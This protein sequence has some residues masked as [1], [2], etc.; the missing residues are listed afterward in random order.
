MLNIQQ[1]P[2]PHS[3]EQALQVSWLLKFKELKNVE[4]YI[5]S[6]KKERREEEKKKQTKKSTKNQIPLQE[7]NILLTWRSYESNGGSQWKPT[8][9]KGHNHFWH[10]YV[11]PTWAY[12]VSVGEVVHHAENSY[13]RHILSL[14]VPPGWHVN[15]DT[16]PAWNRGGGGEKCQHDAAFHH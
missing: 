4:G 10:H 16:L 9:D 1:E 2:G 13:S 7:T 12:L 5:F 14:Q 8:E 11:V 3:S 15:K 6:C